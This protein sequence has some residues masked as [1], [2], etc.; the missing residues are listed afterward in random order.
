MLC[1]VQSLHAQFFRHAKDCTIT[2]HCENYDTDTLTSSCDQVIRY[3]NGK[4]VYDLDI[5]SYAHGRP[6]T[7]LV[8]TT[9]NERGEKTK[10][11][12]RTLQHDQCETEEGLCAVLTIAITDF[13]DD[14]AVTRSWLIQEGDTNVTLDT[15]FFYP[16]RLVRSHVSYEDEEFVSRT[17][18]EYKFY[19][20]GRISEIKTVDTA[21]GRCFTWI[22][23]NIFYKD[24]DTL[25]LYAI[26]FDG[27]DSSNLRMYTYAYND[28]LEMTGRWLMEDGK[29]SEFVVVHY[30]DEGDQKEA[31]IYAGDS[32]VR[33]RHYYWWVKVAGRSEMWMS[34]E[35]TDS[36]GSN[37]SFYLRTDTVKSRRRTI[38]ST[39]HTRYSQDSASRIAPP[40]SE[41]SF[42][43]NV[44]DKYG[45]MVSQRIYEN[46]GGRLTYSVTF[47]YSQ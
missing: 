11:Y 5:T 15:V 23:G 20:D 27:R 6:D 43:Q 39:Y 36:P 25:S 33:S 12:R 24:E 18:Y 1:C 34:Q 17:D 44:Y 13:S 42:G 2:I 22:E 32:S 21:D 45:R 38:I 46:Y 28:Q 9:Y 16:N 19:E 29:L 40:L 30:T 47:R 35:Y 8:Q 31:F 26:G 7:A 3:V 4:E 41:C 14:F 10:V 37:G